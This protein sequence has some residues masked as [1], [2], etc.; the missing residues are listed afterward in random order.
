MTVPL[1]P[2]YKME[3]QSRRHVIQMGKIDGAAPKISR[4]PVTRRIVNDISDIAGSHPKDRGSI[5]EAM[6]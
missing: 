1:N 2:T 5:P 6:K 3:T 4:S